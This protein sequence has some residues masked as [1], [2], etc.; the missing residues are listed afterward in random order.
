MLIKEMTNDDFLYVESS[1]FDMPNRPRIRYVL[2]I[3]V[4]QWVKL[5]CPEYRH[6]HIDYVGHVHLPNRGN[7]STMVCR[8]GFAKTNKVKYLEFNKA[9]TMDLHSALWP[10]VSLDSHL[11]FSPYE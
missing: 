11:I 6:Y 2:G 4:V 8:M 9:L 10:L 7:P 1:I 3:D 5:N